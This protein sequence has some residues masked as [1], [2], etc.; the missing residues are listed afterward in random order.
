M[1]PLHVA[2]RRKAR[3]IDGQVGWKVA[4]L[5]RPVASYSVLSVDQRRVKA[6]GLLGQL[7]C[8]FTSA[9]VKRSTGVETVKVHRW[10]QRNL[11]PFV[12]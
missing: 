4:H 9:C 2:L 8:G 1:C 6:L 7:I 5:V 3:R 12:S 11:H 10:E